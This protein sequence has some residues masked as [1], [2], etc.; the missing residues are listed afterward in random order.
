MPLFKGKDACPLDPNSYRGITLLSV[1][2]KLF[3]VL[4]WRRLEG[5]WTGVGAVSGL[6]NAC[7][8]G[9]SCLH[10][11]LLLNETVATSMEDNELVYIAFFDVAK[12]FDS[13]WVEGSFVQLW[14]IGVRR[15]TWRL[16]YRCYL[17]FWCVARVQGHV[18]GWYQLKCGIHQGG[19]MSLI[20]YTAFINSL[21]VALQNSDLCCSIRRIPSMPVGYADDLAAC[22]L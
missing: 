4:V 18:S 15:K 6:Q 16:L 8:K 7:K 11:S 19:N 13:V 3:E 10:T 1:F 20:K 17:D 5:W 22:C 21:L 12:A 9:R 2:N 14:D